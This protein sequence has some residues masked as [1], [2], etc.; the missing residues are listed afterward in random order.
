MTTKKK[1]GGFLLDLSSETQGKR[2]RSSKTPWRHN[3]M[4]RT[5]RARMTALKYR[6]EAAIRAAVAK[7]N[8]AREAR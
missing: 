7:V 8:K 3:A 1:P 4:V 5:R 6:R 2:A